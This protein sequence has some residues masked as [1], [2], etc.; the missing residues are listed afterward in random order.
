MEYINI[1]VEDRMFWGMQDFY[2]AQ[3]Y[4]IFTNLNPFAQISPRFCPNFP[5]SN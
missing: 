3:T 5:K 4:S 2:F 1:A